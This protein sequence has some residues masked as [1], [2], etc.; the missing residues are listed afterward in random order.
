MGVG[1]G[2]YNEV[3]STESMWE[4]GKIFGGWIHYFQA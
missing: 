1:E 3:I 4:R 2:N